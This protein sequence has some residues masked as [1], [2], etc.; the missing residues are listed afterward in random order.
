MRKDILKYVE[1]VYKGYPASEVAAQ[2]Y[3]LTQKLEEEMGEESQL[4]LD[5]SSPLY[6]PRKVPAVDVS[7]MEQK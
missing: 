6:V 2:E 5:E 3:I 1:Q 4:K 7:Q